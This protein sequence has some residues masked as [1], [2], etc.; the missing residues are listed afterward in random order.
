[1]NFSWSSFVLDVPRVL[2]THRSVIGRF[3]ILINV[4]LSEGQRAA[5]IARPME[6]TGKWDERLWP[7]T[8]SVGQ[9][10]DGEKESKRG[11]GLSVWGL[12]GLTAPPCGSRLSGGG[13]DAPL[14][15]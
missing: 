3:G 12:E 8:T 9:D 1:V 11:K 15:R 2:S 14:L 4:K 7:R 10:P 13:A 5:V 6:D